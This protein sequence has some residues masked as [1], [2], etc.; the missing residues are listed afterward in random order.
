MLILLLFMGPISLFIILEV[1]ILV[2]IALKLVLYLLVLVFLVGVFF[3][4]VILVES[5][6]WRS[7]PKVVRLVSVLF[8]GPCLLVM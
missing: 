7:S 4:V 2:L 5:N 1:I 6:Y 3:Q 8:V